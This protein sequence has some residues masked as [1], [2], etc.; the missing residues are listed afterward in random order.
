MKNT[1]AK[2]IEGAAKEEQSTTSMRVPSHSRKHEHDQIQAMLQHQAD[3][4]EA[5]IARLHTA[6]IELPSVSPDG[7]T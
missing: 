1:L 4:L 2:E 6:G 5:T 7:S 3:L